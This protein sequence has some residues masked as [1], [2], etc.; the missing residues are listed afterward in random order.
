MSQS[1]FI[2]KKEKEGGCK[3]IYCHH[4][5]GN[6]L[7]ILNTFYDSDAK[8]DSLI[9]LGALSELGS[10]T[11]SNFE[12]NFY[13]QDDTMPKGCKD[14]HRW[15][16]EDIKIIKT[17]TLEEMKDIIVKSW[18]VSGYMYFNNCWKEIK[19]EA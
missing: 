14:Y 1:C 6:T 5:Y 3:G 12:E 7:S 10:D 17:N 13:F 18:C 9:N 8:A 4:D 16:G 15:R 11:V 19:L 2:V